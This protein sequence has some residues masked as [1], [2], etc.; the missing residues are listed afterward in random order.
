MALFTALALGALSA[1][2]ARKKR[3]SEAKA[4]KDL[5]RAQQAAY[6]KAAGFLT[7]E[8]LAG[9]VSKLTPLFRENIASMFEPQVRQGTARALGRSGL[10]D[11]RIG[12]MMTN[13][14]AQAPRLS[15]FQS[16]LGAG[17][18]MG[19]EQANI[20]LAGAN[21]AP[22]PAKSSIY[23]SLLQGIGTGSEFYSLFNQPK[24]QDQWTDRWGITR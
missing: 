21:L 12:E 20:A 16:A 6:A 15:A 3:K 11:T 17:Q 5:R 4:A 19:S 7:P 24:G 9:R 14:A 22:A 13:A 8:A 18:Q 10:G 1:L 23:E 2:S